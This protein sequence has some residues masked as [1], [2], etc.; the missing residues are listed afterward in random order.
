MTQVLLPSLNP[1]LSTPKARRDRSS[2][3]RQGL[4]HAADT[5]FEAL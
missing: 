2:L 1:L 5:R 4:S 3:S